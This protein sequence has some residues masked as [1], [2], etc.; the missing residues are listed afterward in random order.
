MQTFRT[1]AEF[2][3]VN[4]KG[5]NLEKF[6]VKII[7]INDHKI[8]QSIFIDFSK[9][10]DTIDHS[11]LLRKLQQY[12]IDIPAINLIQNYLKNRKQC[13][14]VNDKTSEFKSLSYGVPQGSVLGPQLFLIYINDMPL[15][16]P[17]TKI[18]QYADDTVINISANTQLEAQHLMKKDLENLEQWC[19]MNKL[20]INTKKTKI[21]YFGAT[22]KTKQL[23]SNYKNYLYGHELQRVESYKY[24]G[25]ILDTNLNFK[26]HIDTLLKTL[27]YKLYIFSKIRKYLT[28][29]ASLCIYKSTILPYIDYGDIFYQACSNTYLQKIQDKQTKALKIC[30][31]IFGNQDEN[32]L[33]TNA[34]LATLKKRRDSHVL[35]FMY[36]RKGMEIYLDRRDLPTRTHEATTFLVP[37]FQLTQ[38][39]NSLLYKGAI[40]WNQSPNEL[41]QIDTYIAFKEK[42]KLLSKQ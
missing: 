37:N 10:F 36:K 23:T 42:T 39:K 9:A 34:N 27:R 6:R 40:M 24:L 32:I 25:V 26:L 41:K 1:D 16:F 28:V 35:N 13:V 19:N 3:N 2:L 8:T 18:Y 33:H 11:I 4:E 30:Y 12:F 38:F 14:I 29:Q 20:T 7:S 5:T 31:N 15:I 21:M 22:N 17:D